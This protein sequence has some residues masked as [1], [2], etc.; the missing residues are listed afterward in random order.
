MYRSRKKGCKRELRKHKNQ[1]IRVIQRREHRRGTDKCSVQRK[2]QVKRSSKMESTE[3]LQNHEL[4][5]KKR[6][7]E[8][9]L[10]YIGLSATNA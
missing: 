10:V 1:G 9:R 8:A 7:A 5:T 2:N 6:N 4:K 3:V